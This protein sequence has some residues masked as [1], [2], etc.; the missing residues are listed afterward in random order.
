MVVETV[1]SKCCLGM[2]NPDLARVV[3]LCVL[4]GAS[5]GLA[6]GGRAG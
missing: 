3:I 1:R 2:E 6:F 4:W 5:T